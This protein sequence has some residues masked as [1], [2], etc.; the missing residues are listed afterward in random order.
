MQRGEMA[1]GLQVRSI[2][3]YLTVAFSMAWALW[4]VGWLIAQHKL[5]LPIFPVLVIGSF[6]PFVG[7][8]ITTLADGG[9]E[10]A[11]RFFV[12][13]FD[14]RM[15][16]S[17]FLI[18][19]FLLPILAVIVEFVHAV[20]SHTAPHFEMTLSELPLNYFFLFVLGG[21]L[22]EEYGWSLLSD[23]LDCFLPLGKATL[24]LGVIWAVW[25]LPL[26][27]IITPGAIQ[28][29]TPFYI[30]L[31]VTVA[32]RFLFA[33]TYHRG[34]LSIFSNMLFHTASNL[35]YSIVAIAPS[36]KD[37]ST[38]RLWMFTVLTIFAAGLLWAITPVRSNYAPSE[39][40]NPWTVAE[41]RWVKML[42]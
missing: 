23:Q 10:R 20:W 32:M 11:L 6:G 13:G 36:P 19:F 21:T 2:R 30:F 15:P 12:R 37:M 16:L 7:A 33:W 5:S 8:L 29:Y 31:L 39:I 38:G 4:F 28:G 42:N 3:V 34:G 25:H 14:P 41:Y 22:A 40:G 35:A 17:V 18:S 24:L 26:F 27:F 1:R 9:P